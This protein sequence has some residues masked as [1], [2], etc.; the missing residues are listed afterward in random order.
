MPALSRRHLRG[1]LRRFS[2]SR[3][4]AARGR[5]F[6]GDGVFPVY[7]EIDEYGELARATV[8]FVDADDG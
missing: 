6:G 3:G 2:G 4:C 1:R 7:A 5:Q 8:E